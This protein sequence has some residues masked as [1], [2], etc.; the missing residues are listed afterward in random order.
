[1]I[2]HLAVASTVACAAYVGGSY[3]LMKAGL[4]PWEPTPRWV[5]AWVLV[6][7]VTGFVGG[8]R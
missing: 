5:Y 2:Q 3:A 8:A 1:M 7:A 6:S 4:L